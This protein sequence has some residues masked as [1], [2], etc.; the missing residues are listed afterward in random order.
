MNRMIIPCCPRSHKETTSSNGML[1]F[2]IL[3]WV[4]LLISGCS[5][6]PR[7]QP[8]EFSGFLHNYSGL[9]PAPDDSGAWTYRKPG[10]DLRP[11]TKIMLDPLVIWPS[12]ESNHQGVDPDTAWH[13]AYAFEDHMRQAMAGGYPMVKQPG[14]GVLRIRAAL[15]GVVLQRPGMKSPGPLI[16]LAG[17]IMVQA[18]EKVSG[19]YMLAGEASIE[20]EALDAKTHERLAAFVE[21]RMSS[22]VLVTKDKDSLGPILEMVTYWSKRFRQRLDEARGLREYQKEIQ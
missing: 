2:W 17:D 22:K 15:T 11:Y 3:I 13:L 19:R 6:A 4:L 10:V 16:P 9:R 7:P 18:S 1:N 12:P 14:P 20:A 5:N 8:L 21:N